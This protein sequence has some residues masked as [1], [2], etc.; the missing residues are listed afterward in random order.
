LDPAA[1]R[2]LV[3]PF[4]LQ[5]LVENAVRHGGLSRHGHGRI[6]IGATRRNGRIIL[7]V[8]DDGPGTAPG[9]PRGTGLRAT[10]ERLALL[11][12]TEASFSAGN[13]PGGGFTA[14]AEFPFVTA[15]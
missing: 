8:T 15:E 2:A 1:E 11:H 7:N 10:A 13:L 3:P 6:E 12:G 4:L 14:R 5:P 9:R